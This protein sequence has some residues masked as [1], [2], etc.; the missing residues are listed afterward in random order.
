MICL[1]KECIMMG[2]ND[3]SSLLCILYPVFYRYQL[4]YNRERIWR[5][6]VTNIKIQLSSEIFFFRHTDIYK[7]L[8]QVIID[9]LKD[10]YEIIVSYWKHILSGLENCECRYTIQ[11]ALKVVEQFYETIKVYGIMHT[12]EWKHHYE[13]K[14]VVKKYKCLWI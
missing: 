12:V 7:K 8:L 11:D 14:I 1:G 4:L 5:T 2:V 13:I 3:F 10:D 9:I 6:F